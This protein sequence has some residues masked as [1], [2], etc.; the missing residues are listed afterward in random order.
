MQS[1]AE[2]VAPT[3][4]F[5]NERNWDPYLAYLEF[6]VTALQSSFLIFLI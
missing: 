6:R 3:N 1:E 4:C 5:R 2:Q